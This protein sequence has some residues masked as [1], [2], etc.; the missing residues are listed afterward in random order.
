MFLFACSLRSTQCAAL[1]ALATAAGV[2]RIEPA[3]T[4]ARSRPDF[5]ECTP[6]S[7]SV[8]IAHSRESAIRSLAPW[9]RVI[10]MLTQHSTVTAAAAQQHEAATPSALSTGLSFLS[11][12]DSLTALV[13]GRWAFVLP[14]RSE[15]GLSAQEHGFPF[16]IGPPSS[17]ASFNPRASGTRVPADLAARRKYVSSAVFSS[18]CFVARLAR[19]KC[20]GHRLAGSHVTPGSTLRA[21][22]AFHPVRLGQRPWHGIS[23]R[24]G[25]LLLSS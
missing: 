15:S 20:A 23:G 11:S 9:F 16:A 10:E 18:F 17:Q 7:I 19:R 3:Q 8:S 12:A 21:E 13:S 14:P 25:A 5:P 2:A 1:I 6:I 4:T 24:R 22:P